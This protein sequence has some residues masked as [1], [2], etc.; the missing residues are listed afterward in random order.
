MYSNDP[1]MR[2]KRKT[3]TK[4]EAQQGN[5]LIQEKYHYIFGKPVDPSKIHI[6]PRQKEH[7]LKLLRQRLVRRKKIDDLHKKVRPAVDPSPS[8]IKVIVDGKK[9][10]LRKKR[11]ALELSLK[12]RYKKYIPNTENLGASGIL[13]LESNQL[14]RK[15]S[16][17]VSENEIE[18]TITDNTNK[19]SDLALKRFKV[20]KVIPISREEVLN[21]PITDK[22]L[23]T[24]TVPTTKS[25]ETETDSLNN[26]ITNN[27]CLSLILG[28][29][30]NP[31]EFLKPG[32]V[33]KMYKKVIDFL[34][35]IQ[36]DVLQAM[37]N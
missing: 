30:L 13:G 16:L 18:N 36:K 7:Q 22:A 17:E 2:R 20:P 15:R 5:N 35:K 19:K 26:C 27:E 23:P 9:Q 34:A 1:F 25:T 24:P 37:A 3:L 6:N 8:E 33:S 10:F 31:E 11:S 14:K 21:H 32:W 4:R 28:S 12:A 29:S